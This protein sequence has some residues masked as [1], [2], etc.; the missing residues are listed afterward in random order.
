MAKSSRNFGEGDIKLLWGLSAAR[1]NYPGCGKECVA[2]ATSK[3]PATAR[4]GRIAHI[5]ASSDKGPRSDPSFPVEKR[6]KYENLILLCA[7]H[8]DEVDGQPNTFDIALLRSWKAQHELMVE[9]K[10][11]KE[12]SNLTFTELEDV[13]KHVIATPGAPEV[14]MALTDP[15]AKMLKNGLT[16]SVRSLIDMGMAQA[17]VVQSFIISRVETDDDFPERLKAGFLA[18]YWRLKLEGLSGDGLFESLRSWA[19]GQ[20]NNFHRAAAGLAVLSYL[21]QSCEVFDR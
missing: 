14:D 2:K 11:R 17:G 18:E 12:M 1:C 16:A 4:L 21:F 13:C 20:D 7:T 3:D 10:L 5:I 9:T 6:D 15:S 19:C 8:H